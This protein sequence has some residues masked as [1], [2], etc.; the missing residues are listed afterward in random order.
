MRNQIINYMKENKT[1]TTYEAFIELG[2][3]RLAE[4]IRQIKKEYVVCDEWITTTNRNG[5]K[6][7]YKQYWIEETK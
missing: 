3:S 7:R 1:I 2:C 5:E 4:Y 6:K